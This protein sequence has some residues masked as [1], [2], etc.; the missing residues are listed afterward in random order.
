MRMSDST[1]L[2]LE[3]DLG[4]KEEKNAAIKHTPT[5]VIS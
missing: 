4:E 5:A 3:K 2:S 1:G